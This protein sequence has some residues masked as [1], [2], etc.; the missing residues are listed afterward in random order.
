MKTELIV[1]RTGY[2]HP[3]GGRTVERPYKHAIYHA[4]GMV[5]VYFAERAWCMWAA[6]R[7]PSPMARITVAPPRTMS[8]PA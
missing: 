6:A 2:Y 8:P 7:R 5:W 3:P 1:P 4:R